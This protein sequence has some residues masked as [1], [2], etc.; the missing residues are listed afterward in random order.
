MMKPNTRYDL[1]V[2]IGAGLCQELPRHLADAE[3]VVLIEATPQTVDALHER[4]GHHSNVQ[5]FEAAL[6]SGHDDQ[7]FLT[8][9]RPEMNGFHDPVLLDKAFPGLVR[10]EDLLLRRQD[11]GQFLKLIFGE[12]NLN[13]ALVVDVNGGEGEVLSSLSESGLMGKIQRV[14]VRCGARV[15]FKG[16]LA[17]DEVV[18]YLTAEGLTN[19]AVR[20]A[21]FA[22]TV[23]GTRLDGELRSNAYAAALRS[24]CEA[25]VETLVAQNAE[26]HTQLNA[27]QKEAE[28]A[29]K[30]MGEAIGVAES[31]AEKMQQELLHLREQQSDF[32]RSSALSKSA[33]IEADRLVVE[34]RQ[35]LQEEREKSASGHTQ[36]A[37]VEEANRVS[38]QAAQD[39]WDELSTQLETVASERE[40]FQEEVEHLRE[41]NEALKADN[42]VALRGQAMAHSDLRALQARYAELLTVKECQEDLLTRVSHRLGQA[43]EYFAAIPE[44]HDEARI[45]PGASDSEAGPTDSVKKAKRSSAARKTIKPR[46]PA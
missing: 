32:E 15:L 40:R 16:G 23:V 28:R 6:G 42:A 12:S 43:A 14:T 21:G 17:A 3:R 45:L 34:L 25:R 24:D 39:A 27:C 8:W 46:G 41:D 4:V 2:H 33:A 9:N 20:G 31:R 44:R 38:L 30:E 36:L 35:R 19:V 18:A 5:V 1:L 26:L 10:A 37:A 13:I 11:A 7:S 29:K 22:R